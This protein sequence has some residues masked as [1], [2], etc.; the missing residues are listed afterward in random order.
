M[1]LLQANETNAGNAIATMELEAERRGQKT[2]RHLWVNT[3]VDE[4]PA[5]NETADYGETHGKT[6][7]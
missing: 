4:Q 6:A 3:E 5:T 2:A 7:N 1:N